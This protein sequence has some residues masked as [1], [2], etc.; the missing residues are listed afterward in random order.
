MH[1]G[2]IL[3]LLILFV[4]ASNN[5]P[6]SFMEKIKSFFFSTDSDDDNNF[7]DDK[8]IPD[9]PLPEKNNPIHV[10]CFDDK[11]YA[12]VNIQS[13]KNLSIV[14]VLKRIAKM[15]KIKLSF[16]LTDNEKNICIDYDKNDKKFIDAVLEIALKCG[17]QLSI[18]E[19][20]NGT[21]TSDYAYCVE[22][23]IPFLMGETKNLSTS[24]FV[25]DAKDSKSSNA[26]SVT[27]TKVDA[28]AELRNYLDKLSDGKESAE[29]I[30][31]SIN[32][33]CGIISVTCKQKW[34]AV[35]AQHLNTL[36]KKMSKQLSVVMEIY[37]IT[38]SDEWSHGVDFARIA[39]QLAR[40]YY[41]EKIAISALTDE[42]KGIVVNMHTSPPIPQGF[43]PPS[44]LKYGLP[45]IDGE[46]FQ[47]ISKCG[48]VRHLS[49][50]RLLIRSN[51]LGKVDISKKIPC[52]TVQ[53]SH[54]YSQ[55][56]SK[57]RTD[58]TG[59]IA[60]FSSQV[61]MLQVGLVLTIQPSI[62]EDDN[63]AYIKISIFYSNVGGEKFDP[64]V[65]IMSKG[66]EKIRSGIPI[67]LSSEMSTSLNMQDDQKVF[68][69]GLFSTNESDTNTGW[70]SWLP[71]NKKG[72]TNTHEL[73]IVL[74]T[75]ILDSRTKIID[76]SEIILKTTNGGMV[77]HAHSFKPAREETVSDAHS[78]NNSITAA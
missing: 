2:V 36:L 3:S 29:E 60:N 76:Y 33:L 78:V 43:A 70:F 65:D 23:K 45:N 61:N 20:G 77:S 44:E 35:I 15:L 72:E 67:V 46:I 5:Q 56:L 50:P 53:R 42:V 47:C 69:G 24:S 16:N 57:T 38:L 34:H 75:K 48:K 9:L 19:E 18:D 28:F 40:L 66:N 54:F 25:I 11:W 37:E 14:T 64:A 10:K 71:W 41:P 8:F 13:T 74:K 27:N 68:I 1:V 17:W 4:S 12:R 26:S 52:F 63:S 49:R 6:K 32:E 55:L 51:E 31:F 21:V 73:V 59:D 39:A 7:E 58:E 62:D 22:Y 30:K